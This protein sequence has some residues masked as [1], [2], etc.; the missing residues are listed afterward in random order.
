SSERL[1]RAA[2]SAPPT[3]APSSRSQ[4]ST[5]SARSRP[6]SSM[7][8][9]TIQRSAPVSVA[10]SAATI[11]RDRAP[12]AARRKARA[13]RRRTQRDRSRMGGYLPSFRTVLPEES[14][15]GRE[16]RWNRSAGRVRSVH[17]FTGSVLRGDEEVAVVR[18]RARRDAGEDLTIAADS[19]RD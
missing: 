16:G 1:L 13:N 11:L 3:R 5:P 6:S 14:G 10:H 15:T 17:G 18:Q 19:V 7:G 2:V 8:K 12:K 4:I 9:V